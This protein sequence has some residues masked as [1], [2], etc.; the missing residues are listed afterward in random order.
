MN[1]LK[2]VFVGEAKAPW[3]AQASRHYLEALSRHVRVEQVLARDARDQKDPQARCRKEGQAMLEALAP[4]DLVIG[5]DEGGRAHGSQGLAKALRGWLDDPGRVPC[6]VVGG[7]FGFSPQM[8]ERFDQTMS[9]G[10]YTLPHDL[11]RVVLL[12]QLYRAA[13]ILAGHPYHHE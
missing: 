4:R 1:R 8:R 3:A 13:T 6:L 7:P 5:L 2:L 12:E 9:L 10:P 11:A